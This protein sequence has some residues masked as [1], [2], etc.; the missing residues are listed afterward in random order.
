M[1]AATD[2]WSENKEGRMLSHMCPPTMTRTRVGGEGSASSP[3]DDGSSEG[4]DRNEST[5]QARAQE[6][7]LETR[8]ERQWIK[9]VPEKLLHSGVWP[10]LAEDVE[11][12]KQS[13]AAACVVH[14]AF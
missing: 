9:D 8:S 4:G 11:K 12:N 13:E 1:E 14:R 5:D 2:F 3:T 10:W 6:E 7:A